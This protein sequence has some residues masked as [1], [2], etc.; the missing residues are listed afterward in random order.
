MRDPDHPTIVVAGAAGAQGRACVGYLRAGLPAARIV[1]VDRHFDG[2]ALAELVGRRAELRLLDLLR[3]GDALRAL[4]QEADLLLNL[5]GPFYVLGT[6]VLDAAIAAAVP[7]CVDI[8]DD[9]DA[10]AD[11]LAH[12]AAAR[13]AGTCAVV[14]MGSAPG[15]TNLLVKLALQHLPPGPRS[16]D[17]AWCAPGRDLTPGIFR[18]LVHC[19]RTA[20]PGRQR[21]PDWAELQPREVVFPE[22]IGRLEVAL[23]GHPEPLTLQR[24]LDCPTV[25]RGGMTQPGLLHRSW[26]LARECDSGLPVEDAWRALHAALPAAGD[27]PAWSG[28]CIDTFAGGQGLRFD[29]A[30]TISMEQST[31]VPAVGA[32]LMLLQGES[33]GAGVWAPEALDPRR[34]FDHA[35]RVSPGGGGLRAWRLGRDGERG[36][37]VALRALFAAGEKESS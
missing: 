17:I 36:E 30:T 10:T 12:D 25:L 34:F 5:A 6:T 13:A 29:S 20:L 23:L 24:Y 21:V 37:R 28:M 8:C 27:A 9:I 15:T 2:D 32:A 18:H 35:N 16:A 33:P 1:A 26:A 11:L 14:G 22:P 4:L 3:D 31:A 19:F 7:L